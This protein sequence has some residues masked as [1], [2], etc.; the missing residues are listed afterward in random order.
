MSCA[1]PKAG[2]MM[3]ADGASGTGGANGG[4]LSGDPQVIAESV[5]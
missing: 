3:A 4:G 2:S 5:E 1:N